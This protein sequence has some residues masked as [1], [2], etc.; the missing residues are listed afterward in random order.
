MGNLVWFVQCTAVWSGLVLKDSQD[1]LV[2]E[3]LGFLGSSDDSY[4]IY[5]NIHWRSVRF[6]RR[7]DVAKVEIRAVFYLGRIR[8]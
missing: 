1:Y 7:T 8:N 5:A 3:Y 4:G 2:S 6:Y